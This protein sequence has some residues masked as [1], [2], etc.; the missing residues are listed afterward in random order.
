[1]SDGFE[2]MNLVPLVLWVHLHLDWGTWN[3]CGTINLCYTVFKDG[4]G[5]HALAFLNVYILVDECW[6]IAPF[7]H[8][9]SASSHLLIS[10]GTD[11]SSECQ[12]LIHCSSY[13]RVYTP[14]IFSTWFANK[15]PLFYLKL[16]EELSTAYSKIILIFS[17]ELIPLHNDS[18]INVSILRQR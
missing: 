14:D 12:L 6:R 10:T 11:A 13:F 17:L 16:N 7:S 4:Q 3:V 18:R 5:A 2:P 15:T 8:C 9:I 1:M